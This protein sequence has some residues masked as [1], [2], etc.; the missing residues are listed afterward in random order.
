M[1]FI[2]DMNLAPAWCE[3]LRQAGWEAVHWS[4]IGAA[5]AADATIMSQARERGF[6]LLTHDLDFSAILVTTANGKPSV[7]QIRAQDITPTAFGVTLVR[8]LHDHAAA[9]EQGAIITV[10]VERA[11]VRVLPITGSAP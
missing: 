1:K 2:V 7:V 6:V 11:R 9:L 3:V 4:A 10:D 8:L 5:D